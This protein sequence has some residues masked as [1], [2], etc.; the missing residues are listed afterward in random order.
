MRGKNK[1]NDACLS[2]KYIGHYNANKQLNI[3][4]D[5]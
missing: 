3:Q 4:V 5:I 2:N 1:L